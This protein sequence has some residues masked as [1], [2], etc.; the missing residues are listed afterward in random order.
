MLFAR[1]E[2]RK[3]G[4]PARRLCQPAVEQLESRLAPAVYHVD[5]FQD[6]PAAN[7]ATGQDAAGQVSLR[8][9][10]A[11]A[12]AR[13]QNDVIVLGAGTYRA[14]MGILKIDGSVEI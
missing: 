12:D 13:P 3:S 8:S 9:A 4:L 1:P 2:W 6:T 5:T 7:V 10:L 14:R 11:A